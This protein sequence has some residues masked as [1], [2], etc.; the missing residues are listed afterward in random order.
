MPISKVSSSTSPRIRG[1]VQ[2][3]YELRSLW[4]LLFLVEQ[5]KLLKEYVNH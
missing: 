1:S 2:R 5:M 3:K 4:E